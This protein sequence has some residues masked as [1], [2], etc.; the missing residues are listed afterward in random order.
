MRDLIDMFGPYWSK[1]LSYNFHMAM[2]YRVCTIV[3]T[4]FGARSVFS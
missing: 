1:H 4:D 3:L 2:F